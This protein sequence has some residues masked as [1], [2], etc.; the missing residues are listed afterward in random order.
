M[1]LITLQGHFDI[2][3]LIGD[4]LDIHEISV[5]IQLAANRVNAASVKL[6]CFNFLIEHKVSRL[7]KLSFVFVLAA[8][9]H[10]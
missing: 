9:V 10:P 1:L 4:L 5:F 2:D 7:F 3:D 6:G 8:V